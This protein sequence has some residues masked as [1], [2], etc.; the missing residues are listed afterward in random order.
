[1]KKLFSSNARLLLCF[2]YA[3]TIVMSV[4]GQ[5]QIIKSTASWKYL[6]NGS[7]Q[8]SSWRSND[9]VDDLW[10]SG[11]ADLGYGNSPLT[12]LKP[13]LIGYYFRKVITI[14]DIS[15]FSDFIL[16]VRRDDGIV[17]YVNNVEVYR[18]NMPAGLINYNTK[19]KSACSDDGKTVFNSTISNT[20][21]HNGTNIITAEVH[22]YSTSS[23]DL[24]FELQLIGNLFPAV[25]CPK[26]NSN[27]FGNRNVLSTSAEVYWVPVSGVSSYN[28]EYRI[29]NV[30]ANYSMP[31]TS[32]ASSLVLINLLPSTNY[33]FIVQSVCQGATTSAFSSSGWFTTIASTGPPPTCGI[34]DANTFNGKD[35]TDNSAIIFWDPIDGVQSYNFMYKEYEAPIS[36]WISINTLSESIVL[37]NL[38]SSVFYEFIV[39]SVCSDNVLSEFSLNMYFETLNYIPP[40]TCEVPDTAL[41]FPNNITSTSATL[42]WA[43]VAGSQSYNVEFRILNSGAN[44]TLATNTT[45]TSSVLNNL[46]SETNYECRIQTVCNDTTFSFYSGSKTF[47]TSAIIGSNAIILRGP[48]MPVATSSGITIQWRTN[49]ATNSQIRFGEN[50]GSLSNVINSSIVSTEHSITLELL[51]SNTKYYYSIGLIGYVLQGDTNNYFYTAPDVGSFQPVKFW[52]TGDFGNGSSTQAAVRNSF[53][54]YTSGEKINGWLWLGDN[55]YTNGSDQD[56]QLKVFDIYNSIFKNLPVFPA[57]GNHDYAQSGY[58]SVSS[59][60]V[61]FPYFNIFTLPSAAGTEKYYSTDYANIHFISL[62]SYGSYNNSSSAMFNWLSSDL[63]NNTQQWTVVYFHHPPYS[64]GSHNSDIEVELIDMRNNIIP[65]LELYGVD[66]VLS[67]HSHIYER[68]YFIK[69]HKGLESTFKSSLYPTGNIV[70]AGSGPYLKPTRT[71][72]GTVYVVCGVSGQSV[73]ATTAGYPHNAM[74]KSNN[75]T[76]GSLLLEVNGGNLTCKFLTSLGSIEDQFTIQKQNNLSEFQRQISKIDEKEIIPVIYPNPTMGDLNINMNTTIETIV[77]IYNTTGNILYK[78]TFPKERNGIIQIEKSELNLNSGLYI[79]NIT[80]KG[81]NTLNKWVIY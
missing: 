51:S 10:P 55:A 78:R 50:P 1:M 52:V 47:K 35:F 81:F 34:P 66:V 32:N 44:Y 7:N 61:D 9:F 62:D 60:G 8:D 4:H 45:T 18:N 77:S 63:A 58:Q 20:F 33:E 42:N 80:G 26:P 73:G 13:D 2:F 23:S 48:Y 39:Q 25:S 75:T 11:E 69:G 5:T 6:D 72:N 31:L 27:L 74:F 57:P 59:L 67:G 56:Y 37:N 43:A 71:S 79:I 41:F 28:V 19:A 17:V 3:L 54:N 49:L 14:A 70:Q 15:L 65:L 30:G 76:N 36:D 21:F 38:R 53:T 12:E 29:R 46:L 64:K 68:S 24:T 40:L 16:K 22:N